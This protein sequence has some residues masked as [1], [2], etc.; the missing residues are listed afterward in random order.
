MSSGFYDDAVELGNRIAQDLV[1]YLSM[2]YR[3]SVRTLPAGAIPPALRLALDVEDWYKAVLESELSEQPRW[4][5]N[6][7]IDLPI[8]WST[9]TAT[10][11]KTIEDLTVTCVAGRVSQEDA[12]FLL[13]QSH[14]GRR[15]IV[16]DRGFSP[17]ASEMLAQSDG[18][19]AMTFDEL[20]DRTVRFD[21][22]LS[23]LEQRIDKLG[24]R[25]GYT[26][27]TISG[28]PD[29]KHVSTSY[30]E[31]A[32]LTMRMSMRR[33]TRLTNAFAKKLENHAPM[34]A[35][36]FMYYNF[37][38][39]HQALRVTPAMEAGVSDHVWE[40]DEVVGLLNGD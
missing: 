22:Y 32:N 29:P 7:T 6:R 15:I 40:I 17:S 8:R 27:Q 3:A 4:I 39:V 1:A 24:V 34:V 11:K 13:D 18:A 20:L 2:V 19:E 38:R 25:D 9:N 31:R 21:S 33:F 16:S 35:L 26:T 36:Y 37:G 14:A 28:S 5:D 10:F 12:R 23:W 30:V